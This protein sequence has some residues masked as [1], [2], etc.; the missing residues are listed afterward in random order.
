MISLRTVREGWPVFLD[1]SALGAIAEIVL[2]D[3]GDEPLNIRHLLGTRL[4]SRS[5]QPELR[6]PRPAQPGESGESRF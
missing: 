1:S 3:F 6:Y 2:E 4:T 5:L